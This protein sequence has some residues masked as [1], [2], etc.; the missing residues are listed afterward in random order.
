[1]CRGERAWVMTLEAGGSSRG[2]FEGRVA[3]TDPHA[4]QLDAGRQRLLTHACRDAVLQGDL[5]LPPVL[6][7]ALSRFLCS[8]KRRENSYGRQG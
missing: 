7:P 8:P 6:T 1:M 4:A 5:E 3:H 2:G